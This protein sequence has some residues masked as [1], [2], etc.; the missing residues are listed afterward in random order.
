MRTFFSSSIIVFLMTISPIISFRSSVISMGG[1][2]SIKRLNIS[3]SAA[4][5]KLD[6]YHW[7]CPVPHIPHAEFIFVN[8]DGLMGTRYVSGKSGFTA[9]FKTAVFMTSSLN[10]MSIWRKIKFYQLSLLSLWI[11]IL[12]TI[13][14]KL[15]VKKFQVQSFSRF[16]TTMVVRGGPHT[17][18]G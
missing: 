15:N 14:Y 5:F 17:E 1:Y 6:G 7:K 8:T 10:V 11:H 16:L 3:I 12:S 4:L 2:G 9:V 18:W 13:M